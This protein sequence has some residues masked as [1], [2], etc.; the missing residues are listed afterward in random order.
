MDTL[1]P[2][3]VFAPPFPARRVMH[4]NGLSETIV[5][6]EPVVCRLL[7]A[8]ISC[9]RCRCSTDIP[10]EYIDT[11]DP[12]LEASRLPRGWCWARTPSGAITVP[13]FKVCPTCLAGNR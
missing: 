9:D 10:P 12:R 6:G 3:I 5:D 7:G 13:P 11:A 8:T 2:V 4:P 1:P